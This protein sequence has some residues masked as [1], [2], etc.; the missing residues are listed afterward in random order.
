MSGSVTLEEYLAYWSGRDPQRI[1]VAAT[2]QAL[3]SACR[4][5]SE[6]ISAGALAGALG[7]TRAEHGAGDTQKE[8]DVIANDMLLAALSSAPV[9]AMASEELDTATELDP[10]A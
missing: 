4:G 2:L 7:A 6:L 10:S 5:I 8:L 1:V 3:A 9:A